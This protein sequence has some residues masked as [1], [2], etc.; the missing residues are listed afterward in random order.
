MDIY[1]FAAQKGGVGK[2][3]LAGHLAVEA[4]QAGPVV[5]VDTDPQG[6]LGHW[7]E[8]R[9][10]DQLHFADAQPRQLPALLKKWQGL[11]VRA[12]FLD[13][14]PAISET[15]REVVRLSDLVVVPTKPSPHDLRAVVGTMELV[16]KYD[17]PVV[18]VINAAVMRA[19]LTGQAAVALSQYGTVAP[20]TVHHRVA[21]AAAMIDGRV[22]RELNGKSRSAEEITLLW[23]YVNTLIRK[24]KKDG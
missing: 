11:G 6:S 19:R 10:E 22:A 18:F 17:K 1:A 13:T 2:T 8:A 23:K 16:E 9:A 3:T 4:A 7:W 24:V 5:L 21:F 14:P 12:V 15:I 20:V